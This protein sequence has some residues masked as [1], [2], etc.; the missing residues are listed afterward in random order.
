MK[1]RVHINTPGKVIN[2]RDYPVL[3]SP[4][5]IDIE[6]DSIEGFKKYLEMMGI[7]DYTIESIEERN[8][9]SPKIRKVKGLQRKIINGPGSMGGAKL[10]IK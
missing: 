4:V 1:L 9:V 7:P 2:Y 8:S 5:F 6:D 10:T 3:R